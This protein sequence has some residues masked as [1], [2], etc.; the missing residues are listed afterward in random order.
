MICFVLFLLIFC[1]LKKYT[2][3]KLFFILFGLVVCKK[4]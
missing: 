1:D 2:S 4:K 3:I